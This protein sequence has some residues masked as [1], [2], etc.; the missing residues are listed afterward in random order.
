M[1]RRRPRAAVPWVGG[2]FGSVMFGLGVPRA[3]AQGV[4]TNNMGVLGSV[5]P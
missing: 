4:T 3:L 2:A 5:V 1:D